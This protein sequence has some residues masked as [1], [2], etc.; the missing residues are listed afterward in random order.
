MR[1]DEKRIG[2]VTVLRFNGDFDARTLPRAN[3]ALDAL[4][5]EMRFRLV[6]D[7]GDIEIVTSTAVGFFAGAARRSQNYGGKV[8]LCR[9]SKLMLETVHILKFGS[10]FEQSDTEDEAV[11]LAGAE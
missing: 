11:A 3:E 2:P 1:I 5:K 10:L 4:F 7:V 9:P 6:F 8:V